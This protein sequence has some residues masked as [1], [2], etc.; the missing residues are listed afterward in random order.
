MYHN[1]GK[2]IQNVSSVTSKLVKAYVQS[3]VQYGPVRSEG[4]TA[5]IRTAQV[6][7]GKVTDDS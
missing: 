1:T 3:T 2:Q 7:T 6:G 4:N 5:G